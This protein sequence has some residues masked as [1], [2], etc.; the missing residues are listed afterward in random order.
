VGKNSRN[1]NLNV[2]YLGPLAEGL[3]NLILI[4]ADQLQVFC[5]FLFKKLTEAYLE[6]R[7]IYQNKPLVQK[8][9]K[10]KKVAVESGEMAFS[11][12]RKRPLNFNEIDF[13]RHTAVIGSTGSGKSVC[14]ENLMTHSLMMSKP[15]IYFDPKPSLDGIKRFKAICQSF[16]KKAYVISD[17]ERSSVAFN[18]LLEG[19]SHDITN[20]IMSALEWSESFYKNEANRVLF[21]AVLQ[22]DRDKTPISLENLVEKLSTYHD[23]KSISGLLSQLSSMAKSEYGPILNANLDNSLTFRKI[24]SE[25]AC[26]YVGI[27]SMGMGSVGMAINKL[28][29]GGLLFHSK[30]SFNGVIPNV[31]DPLASPIS[32]FFDELA[33]IAH[34]GFIDLQN[35]CRA[36]G[37]EITFATQCP[38]DL[39]R[40]S[41][42]MTLQIFENTNNFFIFNQVIPSHTEFFSKL[43]GTHRTIKKTYATEDG[44][45][46]DRGTEREVE[47]FIVHANIFR[48]LRVGQCVFIQRTPKRVDLL[49]VKLIKQEA[50]H[51]NKISEIKKSAF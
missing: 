50:T 7:G 28:Y 26:V 35:K 14:M 34:E 22:C 20:R 6:R 49:N 15:I 29:F 21:E 39:D 30:E 41:K 38:S 51:A 13:R 46:G 44:R 37:I 25:G 16:G 19:S 9:L 12:S 18:P 5:R 2:D 47:E 23:R 17:V 45:R 11:I 33:S 24:R 31:P 1:Q 40:I 32:I 42:E 8:R 4:L 36:A 48:N 43:A 10:S 27:S 3:E